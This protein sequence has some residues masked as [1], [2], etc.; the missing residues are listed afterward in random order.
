[1]KHTVSKTISLFFR[2]CSGCRWHRSDF[3]TKEESTVPSPQ[4]WVSNVHW[5]E[6]GQRTGAGILRKGCTIRHIYYLLNTNNVLGTAQ[7]PKS[8]QSLA[9]IF[10]FFFSAQT[11]KQAEWARHAERHG[12]IRNYPKHTH[13]H[14]CTLCACVCITILF[15]ISKTDSCYISLCFLEWPLCALAMFSLGG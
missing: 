4:S 2:C 8:W 9:Q 14:I 10:F 6:E 11:K 13:T 1:M 3:T 7:D 15:H 5:R 12:Y